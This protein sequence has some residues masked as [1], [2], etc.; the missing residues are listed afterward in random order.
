[1][2]TTSK[3]SVSAD[4]PLLEQLNNG[5]SLVWGTPNCRPKQE[6]AVETIYFSE[7]CDGKLIVIDRT[8]SGKSHILRMVATMTGGIILV[9]VS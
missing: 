5:S 3:D 1:M 7:E 9:I 4:A 8:G 2:S 6:Q